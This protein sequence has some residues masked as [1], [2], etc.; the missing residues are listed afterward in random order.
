M[1]NCKTRYK[2]I[3]RL[4]EGWIDVIREEAEKSHRSM[5]S[6]IIAMI[7]AAM[8]AKGINIGDKK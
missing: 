4:P 6:E 1:E 7:E 2:L 3:L 5:N 8:A